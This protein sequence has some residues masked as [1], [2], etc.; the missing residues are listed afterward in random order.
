MAVEKQIDLHDFFYRYLLRSGALV[1]KP[2]Y[3]LLE[4]MLPEEPARLLGEEYLMAAFDYEVAQENK[5]STFVTY[6]SPL[7]DAVVSASLNYGRFCRL[8]WP[9]SNFTVPDNSKSAFLIR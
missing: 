1:E 8:Y 3:A 2:G 9:G 5:N 4:A 6:G 7:L